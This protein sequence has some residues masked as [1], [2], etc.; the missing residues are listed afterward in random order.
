MGPVG[1]VDLGA[2]NLRAAVADGAAEPIA[3]ERRPTPRGVD[4]EAVARAAGDALEAAAGAAGLDP[5]ALEA[6]GVGTVGPLDREAGAVVRP[7][8]LAGVDRV[9]LADALA[10]VV[11]H[12]RV[13]VAN[14]AAAGAVGERAAAADPPANLVYLTLSTG[15]GAGAVVDGHVLV[16][17]G[18]NAAEVGHLVVDPAGR[19]TCG[20]GRPGHWE[21]YCSGRA[22]P[23][24]ARH[25]AEATGLDTALD[26]GAPDLDAATVLG[27]AGDDPLADRVVERL[28][29]YNAIG[30]AAV[31]HAFAPDLIAVGGAVALEN[32]SLVIDPLA[33][34]V[35]AHAMVAVPAIRPARHGHDAVLR[36]ALA[37]AANG[38]LGG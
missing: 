18:G 8:N 34:D 38:G 2:T 20:C 36:G 19:L 15:I 16:G 27:A 3:V 24:L 12:G 23:A 14:D 33:D 22:V 17:R 1:G 28:R 26:L 6:V 10:A 21:A 9:P 5:T 30:V 7:P 31:V 4:G 25:V 35:A 29:E 13:F 11:G 37:V 32:P